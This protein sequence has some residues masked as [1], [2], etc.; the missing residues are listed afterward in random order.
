MSVETLHR[1][2]LKRRFLKAKMKCLSGAILVLMAIQSQQANAQDLV[3]QDTTITTTA[4]FSANSITAGPNFTIAGSGDVTFGTPNVYLIGE[5]VIENGGQFRV[6][7]SVVV[8]IETLDHPALPTEFA[9]YQ[10]HPNP[11]NPAT[12]IKYSVPQSTNI[13]IKVYDILGNKIETLVNEEKAAGSY[14]VTFDGSELTSGIY[15]YKL[16][17]GSFVE[18][19]K[20]VLLR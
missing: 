20:M 8:G 18:T 17:A 11:F 9:L 14:E 7:D 12:K 19:K 2:W 3:L 13:I 4:T 10:N 16:Q 1:I 15:F 6:L 5:F